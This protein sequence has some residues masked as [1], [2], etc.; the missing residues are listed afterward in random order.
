MFLRVRWSEVPEPAKPRQAG[1]GGRGGA[2]VLWLRLSCR[3]IPLR[4][5]SKKMLVGCAC[6]PRRTVVSRRDCN[7]GCPHTHVHICAHVIQNT[8]STTIVMRTPV[9]Y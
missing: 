3:K 5:Y 9:R 7:I 2:H 6:R 8:R 1:V 4:D